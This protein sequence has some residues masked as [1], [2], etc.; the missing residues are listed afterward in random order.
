M[1]MKTQRPVKP[2]STQ[3]RT[4]RKAAR[5]LGADESEAVFDAA[6]GKIAKHKPVDQ[7]KLAKAMDKIARGIGNK[8]D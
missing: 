8:D 4:F 6:L 2:D 3:L 5:D 7:E 1:A